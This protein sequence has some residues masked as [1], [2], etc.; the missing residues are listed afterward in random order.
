MDRNTK[1]ILSWIAGL[2]IILVVI[3]VVRDVVGAILSDPFLLLV[4]LLII[5]A[6]FSIG[7]LIGK[8]VRKESTCSNAGLLIGIVASLVVGAELY[9]ERR[10][11]IDDI[12]TVAECGTVLDVERSIK[13][14]ADVNARSL[15]FTPLHYAAMHNS[16]I[17]VLRYFISQGAD[18]NAENNDGLT[19]LD[20]AD[21]E[22]KK[23]IL[24][25]AGGVN[26]TPKGTDSL[27]PYTP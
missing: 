1:T 24:S 14:G 6:C 16:D 25:E 7:T 3:N 13:S 11:T 22:E 8:Q 5:V 15:G 12:F 21:T 17:E 18:V 26:G 2:A 10:G 4:G 9:H 27:P 23:S 20:V 19:P